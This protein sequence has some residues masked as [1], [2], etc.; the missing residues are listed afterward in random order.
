MQAAGNPKQSCLFNECFPLILNVM[1]CLSDSTLRFSS[2]NVLPSRLRQTIHWRFNSKNS[3]TSWTLMKNMIVQ[4]RFSPI[5]KAEGIYRS[6]CFI[7]FYVFRADNK[8]KWQEKRISMFYEHENCH[9]L[10]WCVVVSYSEHEAKVCQ[11]LLLKTDLFVLT[12]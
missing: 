3:K 10:S 9:Y 4:E 8:F 2:K 5:L 12:T 11:K 7:T 1:R 6:F